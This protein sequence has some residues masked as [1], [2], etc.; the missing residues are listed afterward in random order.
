MYFM[1]FICTA[2]ILMM[3]SPATRAAELIMVEQPG[4]EW[5]QAWNK[6]IGGVYPKTPEGQIAPLRRVNIHSRLPQHLAFIDRLIYTPTFV[7]VHQGREVGRI[8]GYPGEDFFWGQLQ[9]LLDRLPARHKWHAR[10]D[11]RLDGATRRAG[12]R[13]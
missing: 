8:L 1:R 12:I 10:S 7:L 11:N 3:L 5:C 13:E 6:E 4:C 2:V 9:D